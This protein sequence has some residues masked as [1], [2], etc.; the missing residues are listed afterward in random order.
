MTAQAPDGR[1]LTGRF[2]RLTR[3]VLAD[4]PALFRALDD[5]R[6]YDSDFAG[7]P[8]GRPSSPE[9]MSMNIGA[10]LSTPGRTPYTIH[11]IADSDFASA[12]T[13]LGTTSL[14]DLN[15]PDERLHLGDTAYNPVAWASFVNPECK[16]LLLS[17]VFEDCGFGRASFHTDSVNERSQGSLDRLGAVR[18]G[19]L[20]RH[21]VRADGTFRDTVVFSIVKDE[22]AGVKAGLEERLSAY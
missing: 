1:T 10:S 16:L 6:V 8:A 5:E 9:R 3:T 4:A 14:R 18:E 13:V 22:W 7:G 19:L 21:Q 2:V 20:R 12:G 17:H 11:L 15:L